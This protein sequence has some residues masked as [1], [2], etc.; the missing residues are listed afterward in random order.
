M[1]LELIGRLKANGLHHFAHEPKQ[2]S[3][4]TLPMLRGYDRVEQP[5]PLRVA[6]LARTLADLQRGEQVGDLM[7]AHRVAQRTTDHLDG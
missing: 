4:I 7:A 2:W 3:P 5:L 1:R 6:L